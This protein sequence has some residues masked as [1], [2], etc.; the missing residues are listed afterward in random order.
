LGDGVHVS[1]FNGNKAT[2]VPSGWNTLEELRQV[3]TAKG[4]T[5]AQFDQA[6]EAVGKHP[7]RVAKYLQ[8]YTFAPAPGS[9]SNRSRDTRDK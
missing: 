9:T 7:H 8:R 5:K 1:Q 4:C 2:S 3:V 6:I